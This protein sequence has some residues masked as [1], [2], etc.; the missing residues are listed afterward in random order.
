MKR[1]LIAAKNIIKYLE[2][3]YGTFH[4]QTFG[5]DLTFIENLKKDH[6]YE[7]LDMM[8]RRVDTYIS[9]KKDSYSLTMNPLTLLPVFLTIFISIIIGYT[10]VSSNVLLSYFTNSVN[11]NKESMSQEDLLKIIHSLDYTDVFGIITE[12]FGLMCIVTV[13][14]VGFWGG[15]QIKNTTKLYSC[16][17]LLAESI[18]LKEKEPEV[19]SESPS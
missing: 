9:V 4:N 5:D 1:D 13:I 18:S 11:V 12:N 2:S 16:S 3:R 10:T 17:L 19:E 6:T 7:Q 15:F 8:K 14:A